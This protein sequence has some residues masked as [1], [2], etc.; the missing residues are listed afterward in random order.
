MK[1]ISISLSFVLFII[2]LNLCAQS[3][4]QYKFD[5]DSVQVFETPSPVN[6]FYLPPNI[7]SL[8]K[9]LY[10]EPFASN[11]SFPNSAQDIF[12]DAGNYVNT[13]F[14]GGMVCTVGGWQNLVC[15]LILSTTQTPQGQD[16]L[17]RVM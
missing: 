7:S 6:G 8:N 11:V 9:P 15:I 1:Y 13:I 14:G 3:T 4:R 16:S 10:A 5:V 2:H 12:P 17:K